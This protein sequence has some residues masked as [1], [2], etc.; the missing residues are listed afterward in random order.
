MLI[1]KVVVFIYKLLKY[2]VYTVKSVK[3]SLMKRNSYMNQNWDNL[4][5]LAD[6]VLRFR[7]N[8]KV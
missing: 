1:L 5:G 7:Q 6:T 2:L 3:F 4:K 8:L